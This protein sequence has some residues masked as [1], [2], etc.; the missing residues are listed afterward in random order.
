M[1]TVAQPPAEA[2][3]EPPTEAR[4]DCLTVPN[5]PTVRRSGAVSTDD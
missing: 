1:G 5:Y 2:A 4:A 3:A